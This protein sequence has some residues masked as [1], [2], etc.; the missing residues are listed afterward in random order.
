MNH[1]GL[2]WLGPKLAT[3]PC[4]AWSAVPYISNPAS[5]PNRKRVV[6]I[7]STA[8]WIKTDTLARPHLGLCGASS[9]RRV[10]TWRRALRP[11]RGLEQQKES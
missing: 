6:P 4:L 7:P 10:A 1:S 11:S 9:G 2:I 8:P 3:N 5:L